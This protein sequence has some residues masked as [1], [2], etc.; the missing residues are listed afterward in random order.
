MTDKPR[1]KLT[2]APIREGLVGETEDGPLQLATLDL[3][4]P[5]RRFLVEHK[6]ADVGKVSVTAEFLLRFVRAMGTCTEE[7]VQSFFGYSRREMAYVVH[8]VEDADYVHRVEGRITLTPTGLS[9]FRPGVEEPLIYEVERKT[10]RV[11]FD[12][13]SLAPAEKKFLSYFERSLPELPL[14]DV[15]RVS[16]ATERVPSSFRRFFREFAPKIDPT[17]TVRRTLY[18]IDGVAAEERFSTLVRVRLVSSGLKPT[19]PDIDLSE[20]KSDYDLSD[21]EAVGRAVAE[22]V[23]RMAVPRREDDGEAYQLLVNLAP[24]YLKEWTRRD[25]LSVQRFYRHAFTS[26]GDVRADRPTVPI[27]GSLFTMENARRLFE[28]A[29]YGLRKTR[30]AS[31]AV[32]WVVPQAPLWGSTSIMA[33]AIEQFRD[34]IIRTNEDLAHRQNVESIALTAQRPERWVKE[35][36]TREHGSD[37]RVFPGGFEM[38]LVPGAFVAA[39]VHAPIGQQSGLPVPLGFASFDPRVLERAGEL[40]YAN[41]EAFKL[42]DMLKQNLIVPP[43]SDKMED[44]A[45][46]QDVV[47]VD[48]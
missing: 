6:V 5:C 12:L 36:F 34:R 45:G 46:E 15:E 37:G 7:A 24:E 28:I 23:E 27:I 13:I 16:S 11:G 42:G 32:Y 2:I 29:S 47:P 33:E 17:S 14:A 19:M 26:H 9:L 25:G 22:I 4:L 21:R 30:H 44:G 43:S 35:A 10:A 38:L 40:L 39:T 18:S 1:N 31:G 41:A 20:W 3:T 8:E 48:K